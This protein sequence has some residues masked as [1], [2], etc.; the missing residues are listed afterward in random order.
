MRRLLAPL[1][2]GGGAA[3]L[4]LAF[5]P[6]DLGPLAFA[7]LVPLWLAIREGSGR[8][9]FLLGWLMGFLTYVGGFYWVTTTLRDFAYMGWP[10]T[11]ALLTL[12]CLY[13]GLSVASWAAATV[14]LARRTAL[15]A[16]VVAPPLW[17]GVEH[18]WPLI[19]PWHLGGALHGAGTLAQA[20]DLGGMSGLSLLVATVGVGLGETA[21]RL[22]GGVPAR[23]ALRPAAAGLA[24][25][26]VVAGYGLAR[27]AQIES[28]VAAAPTARVGIVQGNIGIYDKERGGLFDRNTR[29]FVALSAPLVERGVELLVWPETAVQE[30]VFLGHPTPPPYL[31]VGAPLLTG[32]IA[33]RP[34]GGRPEYYNVAYLL[35]GKSVRGLVAKNHLMLFGEYLPF[36]RTFPGLRRAFPHA[37]ALTPGRHT[38]VLTVG[39]LRL[40]V[41]VCYEDVIPSFARRVANLEGRPNLLVNLTND[42]W[43]GRSSEPYQHAGLASFRAIELRRTL[44]RAT[45]T[46]I[47]GIVDPRGRVTTRG[48]LFRVET[49]RGAAPLLEVRTLYARVGDWPAWLA[50]AWVLV[51]IGL[52]VR[53]GRRGSPAEERS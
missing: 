33:E 19:F 14:T 52:A 45:N 7:A 41:L 18:L 5:P 51:L 12:M 4:I 20:A 9:A 10:A 42:S 44:V 2:V 13:G 29:S 1:G 40:G 24:L 30:P 27:D 3:A 53:G 23:V 39:R 16:L 50:L 8:R 15:P 49:L 31:R 35:E 48:G 34:E 21:A 22:H 6:L 25:L 32:G 37:G 17:I 46:G 43:F 28:L 38:Q 47:S 26:A 36:E 11:L